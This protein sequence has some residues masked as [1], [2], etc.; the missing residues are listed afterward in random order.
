MTGSRGL[1]RVLWGVAVVGATLAALGWRRGISDRGAPP[2]AI[3]LTAPDPQAPPS[4]DSVTKAAAYLA[5]HDPFRLNRRPPAVDAAPSEGAPPPPPAPKPTL[6]L[7]GIVGTAPRWQAVLDGF[8]GR[9]GSVLLSPGDTLGV[10][11]VKR[12]GRDTVIV[13]GAD[14][15][16]KLTV[17]RQWQ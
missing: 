6:V 14:T 11:R 10:F 8:P 16:W 13:Q 12:I 5:E 3:V 4:A 15:T 9:D 7:R 17:R 2:A 1:E